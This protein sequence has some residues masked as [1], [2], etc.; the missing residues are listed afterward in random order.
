MWV[1]GIFLKLYA[2]V[3]LL[4]ALI[5]SLRSTT[6]LWCRQI[7]WFVDALYWNSSKC[8]HMLIEVFIIIRLTAP[9]LWNA[10]KH[11]EAYFHLALPLSGIFKINCCDISFVRS[12]TMLVSWSNSL[13]MS[14]TLVLMYC[15]G[16]YGY[17]D[18]LI[19]QISPPPHV[20]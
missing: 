11:F 4:C 12:I 20:I 15:R 8:M 3:K 6:N 1:F 19:G 17:G 16:N 5:T 7:Y 14:S 18:F 2:C 9:L 10:I 13:H